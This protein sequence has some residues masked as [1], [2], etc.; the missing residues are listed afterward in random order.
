MDNCEA[1]NMEDPK[2]A[3][4]HIKENWNVVKIY[5]DKS[6]GH[7]LYTWDDGNRILGLCKTCNKYILCQ[8]SEYHSFKDND[9]YYDD[10]FPVSS[11]DEAE[12]LNKKYNGFEIEKQFEKRWL[13]VANDDCH[14]IN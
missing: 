8:S 4:N 12:E 2:E 7:N 11:I 14:W 10:Y 5:D 9:S 3:L 6:Y 1:F 13:S